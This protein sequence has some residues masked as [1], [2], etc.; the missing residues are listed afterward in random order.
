MKNFLIFL[1]GFICGTVL[2]FVIV[3]TTT[4]LT[5]KSD[6]LVMFEKD[7]E[8]FDTDKIV[9]FQA[10][11]EGIALAQFGGPD[12]SEIG[13][14]LSNF[15][16]NITG[17]TVLLLDEKSKKSFYD[18]EVISIPEGMCAKQVGTFRYE[19]QNGTFI[20]VPVVAIK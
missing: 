13:V 7:G 10:M 1:S 18:G 3:K 17:T 4:L 16:R 14:V 15:I 19:T 8:C 5:N 11:G 6:D 9:V 20:T 12:D 2:L